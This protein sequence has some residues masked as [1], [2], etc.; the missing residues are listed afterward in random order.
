[1]RPREPFQKAVDHAT[2]Q[3]VGRPSPGL[4]ATPSEA[5][6][7]QTPHPACGHTAPDQRLRSAPHSACGHPLPVRG[8]KVLICGRLRTWPAVHPLPHAPHPACWPALTRPR[9]PR[10][11]TRPA[12]TL[13]PP[14]GE[15][16]RHSPG[17]PWAPASGHRSG[18]PLTRPA[19][20]LSPH[21]GRGAALS[22]QIWPAVHTAR[23][24]CRPLPQTPHPAC[25]H[26][27]PARGARG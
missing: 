4:S 20:T 23:P 26:P 17:S 7:R 27:L 8:A 2:A 6:G 14:R 19:A 10:P 24:R 16:S 1:M 21:A 25:G 5:E 18:G 11:L 13:S 3:A 12:A 15:G 9:G 22:P